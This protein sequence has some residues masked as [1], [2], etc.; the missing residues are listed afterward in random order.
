MPSVYTGHPSYAYPRDKTYAEVRGYPETEGYPEVTEPAGAYPAGAPPLS[1]VTAGAPAPTGWPGLEMRLVYSCIGMCDNSKVIK[2]SGHWATAFR[3][4]L[5][6]LV[7]FR[8]RISTLLAEITVW[9]CCK[10]VELWFWM[11]ALFWYQVHLYNLLRKKYEENIGCAC[12]H[13]NKIATD[14][15]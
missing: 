7:Y 2:W 6:A 3:S 13:Y 5:W 8:V 15:M 11:R 1:T 10:H 14:N 9:R 4:N 12:E